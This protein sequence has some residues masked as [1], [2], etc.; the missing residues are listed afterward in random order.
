M[1]KFIDDRRQ[2]LCEK[3]IKVACLAQ[4]AN[5][6]ARLGFQPSQRVSWKEGA[7]NGQGRAQT[8][9]PD[10]HLV[11]ALRVASISCGGFVGGPVPEAA[12]E[13][14]SKALV[15]RRAWVERDRPRLVPDGESVR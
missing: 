8:S 4:C 13:H 11:D 2:Q 15:E 6:M 3:D 1:R 9:Q 14:G 7:E 5:H 10:A 12:V